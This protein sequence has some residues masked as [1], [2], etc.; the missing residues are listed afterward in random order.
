[1]RSKKKTYGLLAVFVVLLVPA[2]LFLSDSS[3]ATEEDV[4]LISNQNELIMAF[5]EKDPDITI[6]VTELNK[7]EVK[8]LVEKYPA[9]YGNLPEKT[10]YS[11]IYEKDGNGYNCIVDVEK[12]ETL[13]CIKTLAI[14]MNI[15]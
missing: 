10:L 14:G 11:V 12:K 15:G 2:V 8:A 7:I 9:V 4:L 6:N 13:T 3:E 1:M 5:V